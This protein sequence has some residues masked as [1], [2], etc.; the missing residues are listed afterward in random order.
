MVATDAAAPIRIMAV[1]TVTAMLVLTG[2]QSSNRRTGKAPTIT[3][4]TGLYPLAEAARRI[5]GDAVSVRD[6]VPAGTDPRTYR[7]GP[8]QVAEVQRAAVVIV[9]GAGF[10][11]SLEAAASSALRLVDLRAA[12][13]TDDPYVWLDP[14]LMVR[15]ISAIAAA[16]EAANPAA[17]IRYRDGARAFSAEVASTGIDYQSTLSVCPRRTIVT[18]DGAFL[19]MARAYGLT[20]Q[21]VGPSARGSAGVGAD[22]AADVAGG[23]T[24][25]FREPFVT[26]DAISAVATAAHLKVRTLDPL[27]GPPPGGWPRQADYLRLM[28]ANLGA[29]NRALGCPDTGIGG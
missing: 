23:A 29:L 10:Q 20:D 25:A 19:G 24:T 26:G 12:L 8:T 3:V 16:L 11:P 28:E 14:A 6:V 1:L 4:V 21:I 5:G 15:A 22:V 7:L 27:T 9:A 2:C 18:A 13:P 17:S